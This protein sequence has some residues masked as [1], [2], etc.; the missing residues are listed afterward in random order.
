MEKLLFTLMSLW[1]HRNE[2][3]VVVHTVAGIFHSHLLRLCQCSHSAEERE[4]PTRNSFSLILWALLELHL[5]FFLLLSNVLIENVVLGHASDHSRGIGNWYSSL[6]LVE[7]GQFLHAKSVLFCGYSLLITILSG[8]YIWFVIE[9]QRTLETI[10]NNA[11][12][13]LG[14]LI[15]DYGWFVNLFNLLPVD[16]GFLPISWND[17]KSALQHLLFEF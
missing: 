2:W 14:K 8:R 3:L 6:I 13:T 12:F 11:S 16:Y 5:S 10:W 1:R 9:D 4:F 15:L 17:A 7:H